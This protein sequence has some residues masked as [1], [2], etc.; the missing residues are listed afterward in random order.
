VAVE[1][2]VEPLPDP[3]DVGL[4]TLPL[5]VARRGLPLLRQPLRLRELGVDPRLDGG[6]RGSLA[7]V[8]IDVE[9][10]RA[11]VLGA[12]GRQLS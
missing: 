9:A 8:E 3:L 6:R 4:Q 2:V 1:A 11:A 5:A 10:D 7:R 12:E